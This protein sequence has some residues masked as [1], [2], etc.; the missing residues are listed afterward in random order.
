MS[1]ELESREQ[2]VTLVHPQT[3]EI[4]D[5]HSAASDQI[6]QWIES[7]REWEANAREA[8]QLAA[9]ELHD[10]MDRSASWTLHAGEYTIVGESPNRVEYEVGTLRGVLGHLVEDGLITAEAADAAVKAEV[11]YKPAKRGINALMKLGGAVADAIRACERP[12]DRPRRVTL[13]RSK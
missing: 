10:R 12:V 9:A 11:T 4:I 2:G 6:A 5:L 8:K 3:G 13:R 1:T 7:V